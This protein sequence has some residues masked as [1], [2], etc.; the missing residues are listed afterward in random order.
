MSYGRHRMAKIMVVDDSEL[1]RMKCSRLLE[2]RGYSVVE[3]TNG[4]EAVEKYQ[5]SR[6]DAVLLDIVMPEMDGMTAL[7]EMKRIDPAARVAMV[8][9]MGQR[10]GILW[11]NFPNMQKIMNLCKFALV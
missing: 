8:T 7:R 5:Q 6:P 2:E 1:T 3:A 9:A 10:P 11:P 4:L